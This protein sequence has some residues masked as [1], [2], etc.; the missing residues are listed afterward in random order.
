MAYSIFLMRDVSVDGLNSTELQ[1]LWCWLQGTPYWEQ[2]PCGTAGALLSGG[3]NSRDED[4]LSKRKFHRKMV[5]VCSTKWKGSVWHRCVITQRKAFLNLAYTLSWLY[6]PQ[7]TYSS[8][9]LRFCLQFLRPFKIYLFSAKR[10]S[11]LQRSQVLMLP[12]LSR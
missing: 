6:S 11:S 5:C 9:Q 2:S 3:C 7:L 8:Y 10:I 12:T 1:L 4:Y